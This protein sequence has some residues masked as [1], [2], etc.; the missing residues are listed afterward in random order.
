M[1]TTVVRIN[2]IKQGIPKAAEFIEVFISR[3]NLEMNHNNLFLID[4]IFLII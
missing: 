3:K 4:I 2:G 1:T